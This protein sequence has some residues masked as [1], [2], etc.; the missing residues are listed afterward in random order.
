MPPAQAQRL[1]I[2]KGL[3][4]EPD[5]SKRKQRYEKA[6][7]R[8]C[9]VTSSTTTDENNDYELSCVTGPGQS[10]SPAHDS[11]QLYSK[12]KLCNHLYKHG[13]IFCVSQ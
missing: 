6:D 2:S 1:G 10:T 9:K 13:S 3:N 5:E 8:L 11:H 4:R 12:I 7:E